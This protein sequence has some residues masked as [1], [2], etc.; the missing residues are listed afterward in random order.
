[1]HENKKYLCEERH[2]LN[3]PRNHSIGAIQALTYL[4]SYNKDKKPVKDTDYDNVFC[5]LSISDCNRTTTFS[6]G[7]NDKE[8]YANTIYKLRTLIETLQK[9][10]ESVHEAYDVQLKIDERH[11]AD[12][13]ERDNE[14]KETIK[15]I[16][17]EVKENENKG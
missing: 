15:Q 14:R 13:E 12:R 17:K 5:D 16:I 1:M 2:F 7:I 10:E 8:S 11:K 9:F 4:S 6:I 3:L